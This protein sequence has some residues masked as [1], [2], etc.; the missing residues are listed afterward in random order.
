MSAACEDLAAD[1]ACSAGKLLLSY[2]GHAQL[3]ARLKDDHSL[4]TAADL[5]CDELIHTRLAAERPGDFVLSEEIQT[6][7]EGGAE[8]V[9][10]VDP[11]D[12][13]TNFSVG[14]RYW[15]VSIARVEH[16]Q[17]AVA[18]LYFPM[19]DELYTATR[20][21]GARFNGEPL[22]SGRESGCGAAAVMT[23]CSRT[24]RSYDWDLGLKTRL[25]GSAAYSLCSVAAGTSAVAFEATAKIW[26]LAAA[27]LLIEEAGASVF[28]LAGGE[29]FPLQPGTDYS[30]KSYG[31]AAAATT[32][33]ATRARE[34]IRLAS[35]KHR[36][37]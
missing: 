22:V 12:G 1:L 20:G 8:P 11:L 2:R 21:G 35:R 15:G 28:S 6:V 29:P 27:W 37:K 31:I 30:R 25:L 34:G 3:K 19:L 10:V 7:Y 18:A 5:A 14:L 33:W 13:T 24:L 17:V 16:G 26:D 4:V 9:W 32:Q 23:C 36:S